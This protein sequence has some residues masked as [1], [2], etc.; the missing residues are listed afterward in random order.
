MG[1]LP[2]LQGVQLGDSPWAVA[3]AQV[4]FKRQPDG[5]VRFSLVAVVGR[6]HSGLAAFQPMAVE[7]TE[8]DT[9]PEAD[10]IEKAERQEEALSSPPVPATPV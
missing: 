4:A 10:L 6:H 5:T 1:G 7:V 3:G 9:I 2:P 8:I